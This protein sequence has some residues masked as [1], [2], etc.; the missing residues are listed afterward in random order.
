MPDTSDTL[1]RAGR[2][3][4]HLARLWAPS[5][6]DLLDVSAGGEVLTAR[7]R[8]VMIGL[9]LW[10]PVLE[11]FAGDTWSDAIVGFTIAGMALVIGLA[12]LWL[13]NR[14]VR[15]WWVPFATSA[16]DVS[17]VSGALLYFAISGEPAVA[18]NSKI[19]FEVYF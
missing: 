13:V 19:L 18:V 8:L 2:W 17:I 3:K 16:I 4:T 1:A 5:A 12:L 9:L 7:I 15:Q 10:I 11:L 14:E 6:G